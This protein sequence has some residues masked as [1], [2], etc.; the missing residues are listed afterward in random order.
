MS[1]WKEIGEAIEAEAR[2]RRSR[3]EPERMKRTE[4]SLLARGWKVSP[5]P[6]GF[7]SFRVISPLGRSFVVWPYS[8]WWQG[9]TSGRGFDGLIKAGTDPA[10]VGV[11]RRFKRD[12]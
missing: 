3:L 5:G 6:D 8:G 2:E 7:K 1:E 10:P 9:K 4:Q 12:R 11:P